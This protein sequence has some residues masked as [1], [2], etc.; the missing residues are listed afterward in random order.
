MLYLQHFI[1]ALHAER[2]LTV[3]EVG[4]VGLAKPG[5][6]RQSQAGEFPALNPFLQDSAQIV[7]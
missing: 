6:V 5:K 4:N 7:L 3:E 1:Q 2:A